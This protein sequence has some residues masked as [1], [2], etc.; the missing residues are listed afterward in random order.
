MT[1][2]ETERLT[3]RFGD[4]VALDGLDLAV[5]EGEIFG[6]LGP[7]GAGKS[8]TINLLLDFM[9]P[10]EGRA[11]VLG[12][13][14]HRESRAIRSRVGVLAEGI[15]LYGRLTGRRHL[16][17]A[18]EWSGGDETPAELIDRVELSIDDANRTVG[19]YSKGMKQRLAI[20]MVLAGSP[21]LLIFDEPS[22]GLDPNG[23]RTMRELVREEADRGATVFFSSHDLGQVESV[24]DRVGILNDGELVT[25]D[26]VDGLRE[27]IGARA[28]LYLRL[29]D[30]PTV[31]LQSVEGVADVSFDDGRLR[32]TCDDPRA[33]ARA[34]G[35][36]LD[37]G[38][39]VLDVDA[40][41]VSLEDVFAAYTNDEIE[42]VHEDEPGDTGGRLSGV[43]G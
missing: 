31:D 18:I 22:S 39:E 27:A 8:T 2:I 23:I 13:D 12:M 25:V 20:G 29:R 4:T 1:A 42:L 14:A 28:E 40:S 5:E 32:V 17:L 33:K 24:C 36:L 30:E 41:S 35:R 9:R 7:N 26:T 19:G 10:T 6:F 38:V 21:D 37:A 3:K 43:F 16:E 15:D 11:S 34:I